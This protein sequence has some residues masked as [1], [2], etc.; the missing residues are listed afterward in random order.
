VV[1]IGRPTLRFSR[2]FRW[3]KAGVGCGKQINQK[4]VEVDPSRAEVGE[5]G[6]VRH[7]LVHLCSLLN[8]SRKTKSREPPHRQPQIQAQKVPPQDQA[9]QQHQ[10]VKVEVNSPGRRAV[11]DPR[12]RALTCYNYEEPDHFVGICDKPKV[13]F[14]L[15]CAGPLHECLSLW[16]KEQPVVAYMGS[17]GQG[18]GFY[19]I[20]LPKSETTRWL[21][22]NNCGVVI[23]KQGQISMQE[24]EKELSDIFCKD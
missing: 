8:D 12:Y 14:H 24:L 22:I 6:S 17:V 16:Q 1:V 19:H 10:P 21:N 23:I 13:C 5:R 7:V 2:G 20:E 18:L 3:L 11:I 9:D 4:E 15:C